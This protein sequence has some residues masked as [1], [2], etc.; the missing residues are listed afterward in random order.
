MVK[1]WLT[2][3]NVYLKTISS[4]STLLPDL[5]RSVIPQR[6][7]KNGW[8]WSH[9]LWPGI[10]GLWSRSRYCDPWSHIPGYDPG[11][12]LPHRLSKR[13]SLSTRT[14]LFRTTF[15]CTILKLNLLLKWLLQTFHSFK[16]SNRQINNFARALHVFCAFLCRHRMTT[17]LL[18]AW[19]QNND[20]LFLFLNFDV[21]LYNSSVEKF[22]KIWRTFWNEME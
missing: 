7:T 11:R 2:M 21:V 18:R 15:T 5:L 19:K 22:A 12:W 4:D 8:S 10:P 3:Q 1:L 9:D 16:K 17:V 13:Q 14:V 20:F 6:H